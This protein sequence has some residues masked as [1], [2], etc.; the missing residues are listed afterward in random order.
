MLQALQQT[1]KTQLLSTQQQVLFEHSK[2]GFA[3]F[4]NLLYLKQ[5]S[6]FSTQTLPIQYQVPKNYIQNNIRQNFQLYI[7]SFQLVNQKFNL[8]YS[9]NKGSN[10]FQ[11][12]YFSK[13]HEMR[14]KIP[15]RVSVMQ[16]K[17]RVKKYTRSLK[18]TNKRR[19]FLAQERSQHRE[20]MR[21]EK[22]QEGE[23]QK[24]Q[25]APMGVLYGLGITGKVM[26]PITKRKRPRK[27]QPQVGR[28]LASVGFDFE[29]FQDNLQSIRRGR[30]VPRVRQAEQQLVIEA[31][32]K[33]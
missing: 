8:I 13:Y 9:N 12:Y 28:E 26:L 3:I 16:D 20:E 29:E 15:K 10:Y 30:A 21:D 19:K 24:E 5:S 11:K 4:R 27:V 6:L 17:I 14:A 25:Q 7:P 2:L 1:F 23:K 22:E 18:S 32:D 31:E 33:K